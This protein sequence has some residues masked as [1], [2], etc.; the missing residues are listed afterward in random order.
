M[1]S[2]NKVL[3]LGNCCADPE[4]KYTASG[5]AV[6]NLRLAVNRRW[7][8]AGGEKRE[9][10]L[11]I[12]VT[13]WGKTGEAAA[14]YLRKGSPVL[15]EGR[16]QSRDWEDKAG[17]KR[18]SIEVVAESVQFLGAKKGEATRPGAASDT[19]GTGGDEEVPF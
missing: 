11:F 5:T 8:T 9:E 1:P 10:A 6:A 13:A 19:A 16:L 15:V 3:L 2:F 17:Q 18:T 14:E 7:T 12:G 4:L